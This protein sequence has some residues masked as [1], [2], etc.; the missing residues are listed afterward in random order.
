MDN[1]FGRVVGRWEAVV[2]D[3]EA[4]AAEHR[5]AG[6]DVV[7]LHPG[8]V[9]VVGDGERSGFDVLV[10]DDEF[11]RL[12]EVVESSTLAETDVFR[13]V[14]SGVAFYLAVLADH[15]A[16]RVVCCPL[17]CDLDDDDATAL[18]ETA[19]E[20]GVVVASVRTLS[21][22]ETVELRFDDPDL[23]FADEDGSVDGE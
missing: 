9:T 15:D 16:E 10:S 18:R 21:G 5:E 12:R 14:D 7:E 8:D 6:Y 4:T 2:A 23:F 3:M 17:Y 20:S 22:D 11:D 13:A 1:P 19:D